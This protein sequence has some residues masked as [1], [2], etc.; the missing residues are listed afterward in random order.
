MIPL[1]LD[2]IAEEY[3]RDNGVLPAFKGYQGYPFTLCVSVNEQVAHG[4]PSAGPLEEGDVAGFDCGCVLEGFCSDVAY[5]FGVGEIGEE[6][7]N[8]IRVTRECLLRGIEA[9]IPG[10]RTGDIGNIIQKHAEAQGYGV[11]R[12]LVGHGLGKGLHEPPEVP[13]FG[14]PGKGALLESGMVLAIEPMVNLGGYEVDVD[15]SDGWTVFAKDGS[16]S[17]HFEHDVLVSAQG[18]VLLSSFE[19][20]ESNLKRL[21][22]F[23]G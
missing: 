17:A 10:N 21:G 1:D 11:V 6:K 9:A 23:V 16:C 15:A 14:K 2:K 4:F 12:R 13:N 18:P 5:T 20:I 3:L 19:H 22:S 8:L 7:R